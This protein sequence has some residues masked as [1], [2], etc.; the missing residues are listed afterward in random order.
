MIEISDYSEF[1]AQ[2]FPEGNSWCIW[3]EK[4]EEGLITGAFTEG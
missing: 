4:F 2:M 1:V 3:T